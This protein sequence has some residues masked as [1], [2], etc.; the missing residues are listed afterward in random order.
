MA[1]IRDLQPLNVNISFVS[2]TIV[3]YHFTGRVASRLKS[4]RKK[5]KKKTITTQEMIQKANA[6]F[7]RNPHRS[8]RKIVRE[9]NISRE[10]MDH[11]L[12]NKPGLKLLKFQK[13]QNLTHRKKKVTLKRAKE[14]LGL[15]ESGQL[16]NLVLVPMIN[17]GSKRQIFEKPFHGMFIYTQ[18]FCQKFAER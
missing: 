16:P 9:L 12:Q 10:R 11:I 1:I 15:H 14:L 3:H 6:R 7:D 4:E 17:V 2:R 18:S 13:V 8:D 5:K